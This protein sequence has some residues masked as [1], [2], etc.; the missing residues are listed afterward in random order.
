M[1]HVSARNR[2]SSTLLRPAMIATC[3]CAAMAAQRMR[4]G[5]GDRQQPPDACAAA[6]HEDQRPIRREAQVGA[7]FG[8]GPAAH[9][10][11]R[12]PDRQ[13]DHAHAVAGDLAGQ[14]HVAR[15]FRRHHAQVDFGENQ[16]TGAVTGSVTTVTNGATLPCLRNS[17]SAVS[18]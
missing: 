7:Y 13:P 4:H 8:F 10:G 17:Q 16:A 14:S 6:G 1:G 2:R 18:I 3:G 5:P 15:G 11:K 9:L 12:P